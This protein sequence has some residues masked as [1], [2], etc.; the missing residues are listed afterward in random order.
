[1]REEPEPTNKRVQVVKWV[2]TKWD[3]PPA[4][5][6]DLFPVDLCKYRVE[7]LETCPDTGRQHYQCFVILKDKQRFSEIRARDVALGGTPS[8]FRPAKAAPWHAGL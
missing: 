8:Y 1:M 6:K 5:A 3:V 4:A 7:G 2:Y